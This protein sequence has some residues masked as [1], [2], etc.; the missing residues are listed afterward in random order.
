MSIPLVLCCDVARNQLQ[1]ERL[2]TCLNNVFVLQILVNIVD[3][4]D[5]RNNFAKQIEI[6]GY[7]RE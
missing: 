4:E 3:F 6:S 1:R 5:D 2:Q 7:H